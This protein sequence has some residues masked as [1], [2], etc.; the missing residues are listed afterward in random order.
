MDLDR[1]QIDLLKVM[2]QPLQIRVLQEAP[3]H[4]LLYQKYLVAWPIPYQLWVDLQKCGFE[5]L[6][7]WWITE[8]FAHSGGELPM[9]WVDTCMC[10]L[11]LVFGWSIGD[12]RHVLSLTNW[13]IIFEFHNPWGFNVYPSLPRLQTIVHC[14]SDEANEDLVNRIKKGIIKIAPHLNPGEIFMVNYFGDFHRFESASQC[15]E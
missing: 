9:F 6:P 13:G 15:L 2:E 3:S 14:S 7:W 4:I 11:K 1:R 12:I 10:L 8:G 5:G